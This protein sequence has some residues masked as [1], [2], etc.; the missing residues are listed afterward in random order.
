[1]SINSYSLSEAPE[2][3]R[4]EICKCYHSSNGWGQDILE[5]ILELGVDIDD[6]S[7]MALDFFNETLGD[8]NETFIK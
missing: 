6:L 7:E 4:V 1:M 2:P 5:G 8:S 3:A